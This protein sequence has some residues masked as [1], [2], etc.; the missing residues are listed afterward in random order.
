MTTR[1]IAAALQRVDA[2]LRRRPAHGL[3]DDAPAAARWQG[4]LRVV[5]RHADGTEFA[6]DMPT[7]LGGGGGEPTPGW[8]YRAGI[9]SCATTTLVMQAASQ[10]IALTAVEV[11]AHS[12]SDARGMF[13]IDDAHGAPVP[14]RPLGIR[15][16]VRIA[17][18]GV[19]PERLR[20]CVEAAC[21]LS[22]VPD[23]A[24]HGVPMTIDVDVETD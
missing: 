9:A 21:L 17:A 11:S 8:L 1:D 14:A 18:P 5:S 20:A 13:G 4:G 22:P 12:H 6:T 23:A 10:G 7:E 2:V 19:A 24:R 16:H 3:G 15:L